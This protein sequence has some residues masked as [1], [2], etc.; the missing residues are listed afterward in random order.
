MTRQLFSVYLVEQKS[1]PPTKTTL[2]LFATFNASI[3][4]GMLCST[5]Y[6]PEAGTTSTFST[7]SR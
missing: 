6:P 2:P 3:N 4:S 7:S 1:L 5:S